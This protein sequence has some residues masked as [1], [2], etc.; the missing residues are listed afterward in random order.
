MIIF[1]TRSRREEAVLPP[2]LELSV[3]SSEASDREA[4]EK[5]RLANTA[6]ERARNL[7]EIGALVLSTD[8]SAE[9]AAI[10]STAF[11]EA[12]AIGQEYGIDLGYYCQ[13]QHL[14]LEEMLAS[15]PEPRLP[16]QVS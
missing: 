4:A 1:G 10:A 5:R 9:G 16:S 2:T 13:I 12:K 11:H 6:P 3:V 14:P 7:L 8:S 15:L